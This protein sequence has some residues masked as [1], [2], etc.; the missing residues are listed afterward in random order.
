MD[1]VDGIQ[2]RVVPTLPEA[3]PAPAAPAQGAKSFAARASEALQQADRLQKDAE[4]EAAELAAGNGSTVETMVALSKADLSL[5]MV[6]AF[7]NRALQAYEELMR[8]QV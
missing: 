4:H 6:V 5:R 7:R 1:R 3:K 2:G 8:M